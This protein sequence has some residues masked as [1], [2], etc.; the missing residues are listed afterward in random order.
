MGS[1]LNAI[2]GTASSLLDKQM[3]GE[4]AETLSGERMEMMVTLWP[5]GFNRFCLRQHDLFQVQKTDRSR[6]G[7]AKLTTGKGTSIK[8][9]GVESMLGGNTTNMTD[10]VDLQVSF[11]VMLSFL[12]SLYVLYAVRESAYLSLLGYNDKIRSVV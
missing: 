11:G 9:P 12:S 10:S 3:S 6:A 8:L 1:A 4:P 2:D 5:F 7:N